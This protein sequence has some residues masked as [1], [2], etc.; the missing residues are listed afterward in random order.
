M[1]VLVTGATG[2]IGN[3]L[4]RELL[5]HGEKVRVI[6]PPFEDDLPLKG[7]DVEAVPGDVT[8]KET[9][10][11]ACRGIDTVYHLAGIISISSGRNDL[12]YKVNVGGT[13]NII[14]ACME[15]GVKRLVYTSSIHA[16]NEP[17][18]GIVI[19]ETC[20][21]DPNNVIGEYGKCKARASL[22]VQDAVGRGLDAVL[23]CPTGVI[24]PYDFK[25]SE[26]GQLILD[27][28]RRKL[29]AY[30]DGAYDFADVRDVARGM[31]L[32]GKRGIKGETYILSGEQ[33]TVPQ[34]MKILEESTGV[35]R[36]TFKVPRW[37]ARTAGQ[38]APIY[39]RLIKSKPL[40]TAYS[41]DVLASN[42]L[43][44]S[45][46]A[47]RDLGYTTRPAHESISDA[48]NWFGQYFK[49]LKLITHKV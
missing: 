47:R 41:V 43:V 35:K 5:E 17:P 27:F 44:T 28:I 8:K 12:I 11:N 15:T 29:R 42:S 16:L 33:V 32:A 40:F 19:D 23:V 21:F 48:V 20:N 24:G 9:L 1:S 39:Y 14:E 10:V 4:V 6:M 13:E 46:K 25:I 45:A 34:L 31:R 49:Q 26:M 30:L 22:K 2:H 3:V 37:L 7:L 18:H 38:A 36:P